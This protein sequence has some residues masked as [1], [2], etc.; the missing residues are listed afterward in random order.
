MFSELGCCSDP[1]KL[2]NAADSP[3]GFT[4]LSLLLLNPV[5]CCIEQLVW[6]LLWPAQLGVIWLSLLL[7]K[8][9]AAALDQFTL[10][11]AVLAPVA[12]HHIAEHGRQAWV[13]MGKQSRKNLLFHQLLCICHSSKDAYAL[14]AAEHAGGTQTG[15]ACGVA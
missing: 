13:T 8:P 3:V 2:L 4:W 11:L 14:R 9:V 1:S 15:S 7:L 10:A 12:D 5:G 6:L